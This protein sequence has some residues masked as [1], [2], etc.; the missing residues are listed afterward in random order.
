MVPA[1]QRDE[2]ISR[3]WFNEVDRHLI[4]YTFLQRATEVD[5]RAV[6]PKPGVVE[7]WRGGALD[8][9]FTKISDGWADALNKDNIFEDHHRTPGIYEQ[10]RLGQ[11]DIDL[12]ASFEVPNNA[13]IKDII[14]QEM[15]GDLPS[16][17]W[18]LRQ[19]LISS[20]PRYIVG[21]IMTINELS[22]SPAPHFAAFFLLVSVIVPAY[23]GTVCCCWISAGC[24]NIFVWASR[25]CLTRY[26][27]PRRWR[28]APAPDRIWDSSGPFIS[29]GR[30][31]ESELDAKDDSHKV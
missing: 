14:V 18:P 19:I 24:P 11:S 8:G 26:F 31:G 16:R 5:I 7:F 3:E 20:F 4:Q 12:V 15:N 21:P 17:T 27:I 30:I 10:M 2:H 23:L 13:D 29:D 9:A 6:V 22:E 25:S 1:A 28:G